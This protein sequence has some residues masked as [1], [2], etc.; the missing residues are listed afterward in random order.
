MFGKSIPLSFPV[1]ERKQNEF[2]IKLRKDR[3][4][5]YFQKY[6]ENFVFDNF[7]DSYIAKEGK[8]NFMKGIPIPLRKED[9]ENFKGGEGLKLSVIV[10]NM[11]WIMGIDPKFKH[12]DAYIQFITAYYYKKATLNIVKVGRNAAEREDYDSAAIHFRAAL[13][14][15][16]QDIHAMYSYARVCRAMYLQDEQ[17][18]EYVGNFKAE[19]IEFFELLID[20]HP[21]FAEAYYY[22]GYAYLNM[23][24]YIKTSIIW[25]KY[26]NI[27]KH[28]K[29]KKEIRLR[30]QQLEEPIKIEE[31]YNAILKGKFRDGIENLEPFVNSRFKDWWPL[32]YYLG[33]GYANTNQMEEAL[34]SFHKVLKLN[35]SHVETMDELV[36]LYGKKGDGDKEKKYSEKAKLLRQG[37]HKE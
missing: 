23:G 11:V 6:L 32:Y 9:L 12:R 8:I 5:K 10:E 28:G 24:L 36:T 1:V 29:D 21:K 15:S 19:S 20:F 16:P 35:P 22:L 4:K 30:L 33:V 13:C 26:I 14:I 2:D 27:S 25:G 34:D 7:T 31:G 18:E 17:E 3:I 37:G